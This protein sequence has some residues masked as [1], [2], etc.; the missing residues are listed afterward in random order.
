MLV[1]LNIRYIKRDNNYFFTDGIS[2]Y[3]NVSEDYIKFN[4]DIR[5]FRFFKGLKYAGIT[6]GVTILVNVVVAL[7]LF[8]FKIDLNEQEIIKELSRGSLKQ[9][10]FMT[11]I[12][13]IFAPVLEEFTFR[14][15]LFEKIFSPRVGIYMAA[16]VSSIIF[17]LVHFNLR[18]FPV[19]MVIS[20][21]NCY[22][23]HKKGYWYAVFNHLIFNSVTV[24][25]MFY[26]KIN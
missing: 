24:F 21:I 12:M 10:F 9:L 18:S 16:L 14:W 17:S 1:I 15:L 2:S 13:V 7:F 20:F 19:L 26:Q 8:N 5:T 11:P 3:T 4:F 22:I 25:V 6:Y 23:I